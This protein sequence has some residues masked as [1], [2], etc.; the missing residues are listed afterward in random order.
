[1]AELRQHAALAAAVELAARVADDHQ[2][3]GRAQVA[4]VR[5]SAAVDPEAVVAEL[6]LEVG[7]LRFGLQP[8]VRQRDLAAAR[9][10]AQADEVSARQGRRGS[11]TAR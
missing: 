2:R 7:Q 10:Q 8:G 1:M 4:R 6:L 11:S 3:R 9:H 5:R